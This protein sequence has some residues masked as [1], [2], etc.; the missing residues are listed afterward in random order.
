VVYF[1][2][3][4]NNFN[5]LYIYIF[6]AL[7]K[8]VIYLVLYNTTVIKFNDMIVKINLYLKNKK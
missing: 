6:F 7:E 1:L 3:H 5:I 8:R 2:N 4:F